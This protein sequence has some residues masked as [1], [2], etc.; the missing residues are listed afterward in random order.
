MKNIFFNFQNR[1]KKYYNGCDQEIVEFID[2]ATMKPRCSSQKKVTLFR[3]FV[4]SDD[5]S[6]VSSSIS[7][8]WYKE[9]ESCALY[10][11]RVRPAQN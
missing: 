6:F 2:N 7:A 3:I 10:L 5:E 11:R 1:V 8:P 4:A 9:Q